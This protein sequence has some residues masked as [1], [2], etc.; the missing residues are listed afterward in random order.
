MLSTRDNALP[1]PVYL[2]SREA[3][4]LA[5][6]P[7]KTYKEVRFTRNYRCFTPA[8]PHVL[9][10]TPRISHS[11]CEEQHCVYNIWRQLLPLISLDVYIF[12]TRDASKEKEDKAQETWQEVSKSALRLQFGLCFI[13]SGH[14]GQEIDLTV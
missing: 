4:M 13:F 5:K 3:A 1:R 6:W 12:S 9:Q 7:V 10:I 8:A 2:A 11:M 14:R